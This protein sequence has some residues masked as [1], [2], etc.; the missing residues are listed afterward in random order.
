MKVDKWTGKEAISLLTIL[1]TL[2]EAYQL[3]SELMQN[4][5]TMRFPCSEEIRDHET[6]Q[7]H[8]FGD[9]SIE[10]P[11]AG[12]LG[13]LNGM[14]GIDKNRS[15]PIRASFDDNGKLIGFILTNTEAVTAQLNKQKS[16]G[17]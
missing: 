2:N 14:I 15:G 6:I 16:E 10:K 12:F 11:K 8:C 5:I 1:E 17:T 7:A 3:D 9:A 4:L 13:I